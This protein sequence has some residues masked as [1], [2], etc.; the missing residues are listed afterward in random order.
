M[1]DLFEQTLAIAKKI[2]EDP[3]SPPLTYDIFTAAAVG[4]YDS[5]NSMVRQKVQLNI[6]N[7]GKNY[8]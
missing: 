7:K 6:R 4:S 2:Y 3:E 1:D 5:V 8:H